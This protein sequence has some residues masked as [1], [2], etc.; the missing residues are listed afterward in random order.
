MRSWPMRCWAR[1][2]AR[3]GGDAGEL[4]GAAQDDRAAAPPWPGRCALHHRPAHARAGHARRAPGQAA[5][6]HDLQHRHSSPCR[7]PAGP[8]L[9]RASTQPRVDRRLHLR[10][11]LGPR[12]SMSRSSWTSMPSASSAGTRCAPA[13]PGWSYSR[14]AWPPGPAASRA[15]PSSAASWST[16][17]MPGR[18]ADSTGRRNTPSSGGVD[19]TTT[20]LGCC[21]D[22]KAADAVAW[23]AASGAA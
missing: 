4:V 13:Q 17:P 10:A 14:R 2:P 19:G 12:W 11:D 1:A 18:R 21:G 9:H 15:T 22:R 20:G 16:T 7:R 8:R 23:P 6:D 5:T 3:T